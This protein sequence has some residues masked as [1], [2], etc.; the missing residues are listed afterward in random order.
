[1]FQ[2]LQIFFTINWF[3]DNFLFWCSSCVC[4]VTSKWDFG[5]RRWIVSYE[6]S[7]ACLYVFYGYYFFERFTTEGNWLPAIWKHN[8]NNRMKGVGHRSGGASGWKKSGRNA[9]QENSSCAIQFKQHELVV[10]LLCQANGIYV[11]AQMGWVTTSERVIGNKVIVKV[12]KRCYRVGFWKATKMTGTR[13]WSLIKAGD[14]Y[15]QKWEAW[16]CYFEDI[17]ENAHGVLI[18][19]ILTALRSP[20]HIIAAY[21][22]HL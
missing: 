21:D 2:C 6:K 9:H 5:D 14:A 10:L 11:D 20:R 16:K 8:M 22:S 19:V 18:R 12:A 1:M 7:K 3:A 13:D 17:M 15:W 4:Q